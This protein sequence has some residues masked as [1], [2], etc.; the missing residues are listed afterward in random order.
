[1]GGVLILGSVFISTILWAR[2]DSLYLWLALGRDDCVFG[3]I[4]FMDDYIKIVKKRS[5]GLTGWQKILGQLMTAVIV[6]GC[7]YCLQITRGI[8]AFRFSKRRHCQLA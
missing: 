3:V 1:M 6:W 5:F 8:S 7:L 4:G 2:L